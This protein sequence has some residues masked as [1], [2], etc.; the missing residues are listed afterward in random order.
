MEISK[1]KPHKTENKDV[2]RGPSSTETNTHGDLGLGLSRLPH[3]ASGFKASCKPRTNC[4]LGGCN[5]ASKA[6]TSCYMLL[7]VTRRTLRLKPGGGGTLL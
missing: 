6:T 5:R 7:M 2:A 4:K 3:G 1:E